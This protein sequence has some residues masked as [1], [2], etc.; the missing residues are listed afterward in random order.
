VVFDLIGGH[1]TTTNTIIAYRSSASGT[2]RLLTTS[3]EG[4]AKVWETAGDSGALVLTLEDGLRADE[5]D[6]EHSIRHACVFC[7]PTGTDR[8]A[9]GYALGTIRVWDGEAVRGSRDVDNDERQ[10]CTLRSMME[11]CLILTLSHTAIDRPSPPTH[12][13][14]CCTCWPSKPRT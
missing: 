10:Q 9:I 3:A 13:E 8:M 11:S 6:Y 1:R 7:G 2:T 5:D 12:R 4:R 14:R